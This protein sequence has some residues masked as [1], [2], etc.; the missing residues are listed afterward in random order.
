MGENKNE[1]VFQ[2][3]LQEW[4]K[5]LEIVNI[6]EIP[7]IIT[8][9]IQDP[10]FALSDFYGCWLK[11]CIS[12]KEK[13]N[14]NRDQM[15]L[16]KSLI[17]SLDNR[18]SQLLTHPAMLCAVFLDPRFHFD[19]TEDEKNYARLKIKQIWN[20]IVSFKTKS[21]NYVR[22]IDSSL[23]G[24]VDTLEM[25]LAEKCGPITQKK[26]TNNEPNFHITI[27]EFM[28]SVSKYETN[29]PR[30]HHSAQILQYWSNRLD[31]SKHIEESVELQYIATTILAIPSTQVP[32]ERSFSG[33]NFVFNSKRTA[34]DS[35]L[36]EAILF[37]RMNRDLFEAIKSEDLIKFNSGKE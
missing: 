6:L 4:S 15:G 21:G 8:K 5:I 14:Q 3:V 29:L 7:Y 10:A 27:S 30:I 19:L 18:K 33:L 32:C 2:A 36:L 28:N 13:I 11:M 24:A 12:I 16:A 23:D 1:P 17:F 26:D 37:I 25:Y 31:A 34:I 22:D 20:R 9:Q 35:K